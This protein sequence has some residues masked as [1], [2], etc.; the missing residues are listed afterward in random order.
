MNTHTIEKLGYTT[1]GLIM[2]VFFVWI[3]WKAPN[4]AYR[5]DSSNVQL[6]GRC[7]MR[8]CHGTLGLISI[9]LSILMWW[10]W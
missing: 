3:A 6:F 10:T 9:A 2:G 7:V 1:M 4:W 8:I 5:P